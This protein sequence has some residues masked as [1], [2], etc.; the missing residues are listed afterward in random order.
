MAFARV[1]LQVHRIGA[2]TVVRTIRWH[3][4]DNERSGRQMDGPIVF[5]HEI[6]SR[7]AF[8]GNHL[9]LIGV[10]ENEIVDSKGSRRYRVVLVDCLEIWRLFSYS[11]IK[12]SC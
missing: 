4:L 1:R 10:M 12:S 2:A 8:V 5:D 3:T 9:E 6:G 11:K 7:L